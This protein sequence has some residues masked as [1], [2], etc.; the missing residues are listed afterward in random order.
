MKNIP[1]GVSKGQSVKS[2]K[3]PDE[4]EPEEN[5]KPEKNIEPEP[6]LVPEENLEPEDERKS[7]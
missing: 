2:R 6:N 3:E 5:L 1:N 7:E 4:F